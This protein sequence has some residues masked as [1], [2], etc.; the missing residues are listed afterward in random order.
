VLPSWL[1]LFLDRLE[2]SRGETAQAILRESASWSQTQVAQVKR[3]I[4]YV[5]TGLQDTPKDNVDVDVEAATIIVKMSSVYGSKDA[6]DADRAAWGEAYKDALD[7]VPVWALREAM[8][9]WHRGECGKDTDGEPFVY[10]FA[11]R[12]AQIRHIANGI[13]SLER[14]RMNQLIKATEK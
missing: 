14:W 8:R 10:R 7:D 2:G 3:Y 1:L 6:A 13:A 5:A 12:P 4:T 11:P 9:R